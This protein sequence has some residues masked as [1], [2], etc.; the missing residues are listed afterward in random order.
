M[1]RSK[2]EA[3]PRIAGTYPATVATCLSALRKKPKNEEAS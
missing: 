1:A 3:S 2:K